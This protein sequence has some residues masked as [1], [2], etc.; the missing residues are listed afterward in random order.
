MNELAQAWL[1]AQPQVCSV[2]TGA[3]RLEQVIQNVKAAS[4]T[5]TPAELDEVNALL[6]QSG[7]HV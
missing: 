2:T 6:P 5:L 7:A 1:M 4:W 3:T